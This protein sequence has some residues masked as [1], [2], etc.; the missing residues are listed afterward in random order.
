MVTQERR[1]G[2]PVNTKEF[3]ALLEKIIR[4][5]PLT[6]V[7]VRNIAEFVGSKESTEAQRVAIVTA[8]G[9]WYF[10]FKSGTM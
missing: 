3:G 8:L 7:E 6:N 9:M 4:G 10:R 1:K 2:M 5:E